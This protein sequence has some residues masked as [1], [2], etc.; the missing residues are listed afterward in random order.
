[1]TLCMANQTKY[2]HIPHIQTFWQEIKSNAKWKM[3]F[4]DQHITS[5]TSSSM[6][7][8][9][10]TTLTAQHRILSEETGRHELL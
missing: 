2:R 10:K 3:A 8:A 9:F 7:L 1:M 5:L 4:I 6:F